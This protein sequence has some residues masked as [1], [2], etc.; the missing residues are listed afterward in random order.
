MKL[1]FT[2][3]DLR[4]SIWKKSGRAVSPLTADGAHGVARPTSG[5]TMAEIAISLAVIGI[6]LVAII[7]V[8]PIGMRM[9]RDNREQTVINQDATVL[10]EAIRNGARGMDDLT[11]Y[12]YAITNYWTS[13]P[14]L[15]TGV[16]GYNYTGSSTAPL[17]PI[18]NGARIIGLL[19][20]PEYTDNNGMS[21][22]NLFNGGF[23]NHI[24]AYVRSISGPAVEKPPQVNDSIVRE[25]SFTYRILCV[26]V[27][28]EL[29]PPSWLPQP[30]NAGDQVS[31]SDIFWQA[32]AATMAA[33]QPGSAADWARMSYL[34]QLAANMHELRLTFEW[35]QL[36]NGGLGLGRQTFRT[37]VA[38]QIAHQVTNS[39]DL[40][41]F[42]SQSFINAP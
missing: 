32:T 5:F 38:G 17:F 7:G 20:T 25:G 28:V 42:Q 19:S 37:A 24:V 22:P 41:F 1:P 6:A 27:P 33:D 10:L 21:L 34:N 3:F 26:N 31:F 13:Y 15:G 39:T 29:S 36:P 8:L 14:G 30:Y 23:S 40:Y 18:N 9:Q 35:P 12:V 2:I 11:N 16:N 4:F